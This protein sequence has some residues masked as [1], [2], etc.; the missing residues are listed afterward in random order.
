MRLLLE[1]RREPICPHCLT[2]LHERNLSFTLNIAHCAS[3]SD[4]RLVDELEFKTSLAVVLWNIH[5]A[6]WTAFHGLRFLTPDVVPTTQFSLLSEREW[7]HF[8]NP[9]MAPAI[10]Q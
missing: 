5:N 2:V 6:H 8:K 1:T 9:R 7:Q 4:F 10:P 3:C